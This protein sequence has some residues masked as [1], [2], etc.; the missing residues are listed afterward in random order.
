MCAA[1]APENG[2]EPSILEVEHRPV[3]GFKGE[4]ED[5]HVIGELLCTCINIRYCIHYIVQYSV[6]CICRLC[7]IREYYIW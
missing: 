2:F 4:G 5:N 7:I 1:E 6:Y 3:V